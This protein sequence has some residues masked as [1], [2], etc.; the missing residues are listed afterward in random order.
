MF[1]QIMGDEHNPT[2][3]G[4]NDLVRE[5]L[6]VKKLTD[7]RRLDIQVCA[8]DAVLEAFAQF[9]FHDLA[10]RASVFDLPDIVDLFDA[11]F[12]DLSDYVGR[13]ETISLLLNPRHD[14]HTIR[15]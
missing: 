4:F 8:A 15:P 7:E 3:L 9:V 5:S 10:G 1:L 14:L 12:G 11:D 6:I 13:V 2:T